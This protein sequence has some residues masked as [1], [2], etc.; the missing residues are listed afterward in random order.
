MAYIFK[1]M[2]PAHYREYHKYLMKQKITEEY[3]NKTPLL[4]R[5]Q[6]K[7][8]CN[9]RYRQGTDQK[10]EKKKKTEA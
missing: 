5:A 8:C 6:P 9:G 4:Q 7:I 3:E 10:S 1:E 2:N